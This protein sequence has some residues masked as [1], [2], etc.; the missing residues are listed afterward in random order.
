[1][2]TY[3][4]CSGH[5]FTPSNMVSLKQGAQTMP[6]CH[7]LSNLENKEKMSKPIQQEAYID[8]QGATVAAPWSWACI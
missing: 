1:M 5:M 8:G 2:E 4:I 7:E 3:V 6:A